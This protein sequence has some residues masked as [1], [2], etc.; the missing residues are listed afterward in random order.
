LGRNERRQS[1]AASPFFA[2]ISPAELGRLADEAHL[3]VA[4]EREALFSAGEPVHV[5]HL[6]V[7]GAVQISI[8]AWVTNNTAEG[9]AQVADDGCGLL[10]RVLGAG[11]VAGDV[12]MISLL[13]NQATPVVHQSTARVLTKTA[14]L[15]AIRSCALARVLRNHSPLRD[16]LAERVLER[17]RQTQTLLT[18][19]VLLKT[20]G[21]ARLA[22]LLLDLFD[23]FGTAG[24]RGVELPA[25]FSHRA[26]GQ[27]LGLT[28]RSIFE[29]M[30]ALE[31]L[32][33]IDHDRDGRLTLVEAARLRRV[34][35]ADG[36]SKDQAAAVWEEDIRGALNAADP[37]K[38]R[39][40]AR[41]A[42]SATPRRESLCH[43]AVVAA[44]RS[45][46]VA[47]A[48]A[49][50][51]E[52]GLTVDHP[53]EQ[54]ATLLPD[55]LTEGAFL[56]QEKLQFASLIR[57]A[58]EQYEE[59]YKRS[60]SIH[61]SVS[62]A[63][64][65][66]LIGESE[67]YALAERVVREVRPPAADGR[68]LIA[69]A[70]AAALLGKRGEAASDLRRAV[71]LPEVDLG[72]RAAACRRVRH[73]AAGLGRDWDDLLGILAP[74]PVVVVMRRHPSD[75]GADIVR[76]V[77]SLRCLDAGSVY[78]WLGCGDDLAVAEALLQAHFPLAMVLPR[79]ADMLARTCLHPA[80]GNQEVRFKQCLASAVAH[81]V[82]DERALAGGPARRRQTL[83][84]GV[85]LAIHRAA[86][87]ES[88]C[89]LMTVDEPTDL[90]LTRHPGQTARGS[91]LPDYLAED[92]LSNGFA[93]YV[94]IDLIDGEWLG[95]D[96]GLMAL[97]S[98]Q[99]HIAADMMERRMLCTFDRVST[100]VRFAFAAISV[101]RSS[102]LRAR[103]CC[104]V[105]VRHQD[106]AKAARLIRIRP[107]TPDNETFAS[108]TF[109]AE[110]ALLGEPLVEAR[111][112]GR[113]RS[114]ERRGRWPMWS[115]RP[116][117]T[118]AWPRGGA[119]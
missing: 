90:R 88:A 109:V 111:Y 69:R 67:G 105:D 6:I 52:F 31:E 36:R 13:A 59:V 96:A 76:T 4:E 26:L 106:G 74:N 20:R 73:I 40:L 86:T 12:E 103:L 110:C 43:M 33:A 81:H 47:L 58:I 28:R 71:A 113:I 8:G 65:G 39:E 102:G 23:R 97:L 49:W 112:V 53:N 55:L 63:L 7:D 54:I 114:L 85:G 27:A 95:G 22:R 78:A 50:I 42:L 46:S 99:E 83:R 9:D 57:R 107:E 100:A 5:L 61:A 80:D 1:I 87:R 41:E 34:A 45:G 119:T 25:T 37:I 66:L 101:L 60:G 84:H 48:R 30:N 38:A 89:L 2:G 94:A 93:A 3:I 10:L 82:T 104:D 62:I 51:S 108:D 91:A 29:D 44:V 11:D 32:G 18:D 79:P 14:R 35:N 24:A 117:P 68:T 56:A 64:L 92:D 21:R 16:R 17:L 72:S 15:I 75:G 19:T 70:Q 116:L 98:G 118:L 115:L 77:E